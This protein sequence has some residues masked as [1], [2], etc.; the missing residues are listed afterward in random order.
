MQSTIETK[1]PPMMHILCKESLLS[2]GLYIY[3]GSGMK[4]YS[5]YPF[6]PMDSMN[7]G[8][9]YPNLRKI[10]EKF[11]IS[12]DLIIIFFISKNSNPEKIKNISWK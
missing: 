1:T 2:N 3:G 12:T 10:E 7:S 9:I 5:F 6:T 11:D 4:F 8:Y